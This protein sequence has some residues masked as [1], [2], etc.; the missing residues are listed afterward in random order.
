MLCVYYGLVGSRPLLVLSRRRQRAR[1]SRRRMV[2]G[3]L[4]ITCRWGN[5]ESLPRV[6]P[7]FT[8]TTSTQ[9]TDDS[10]IS[11]SQRSFGLDL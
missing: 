6:S 10:V 7:S 11:S 4:N 1:A 8:P 9:M 3:W 2:L 5:E